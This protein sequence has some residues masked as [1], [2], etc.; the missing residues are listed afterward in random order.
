[1]RRFSYGAV[2]VSV[3]A[4]LVAAGAADAA[5]AKHK[6]KKHK[7][8]V[9]VPACATWTDPAGDAN[10]A[11]DSNPAAQPA[12]PTLDITAVTYAITADTFSAKIVIP[13]YDPAA[14]YSDG[15]RLDA[16]FT[17][18][19]KAVEISANNGDAW[20]VLSNAYR[21]Q[22]I[23]VDGTSVKGSED[24]V[25]ETVDG[26]TVTLSVKLADLEAAVGAPIGGQPLSEMSAIAWAAYGNLALRYDD[27]VAPETTAAT[28]TPCAEAPAA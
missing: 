19:G 18:A 16:D 2:A 24:M 4:A 9:T 13:E 25:T 26:T 15:N 28:V 10:L 7:K 5:T 23:S 12:D 1:M 17:V 27:A 20:A 3:T 14:T 21:Q 22:S 8:P 11:E 6:K